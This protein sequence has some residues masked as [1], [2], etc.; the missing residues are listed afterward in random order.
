MRKENFGKRLYRVVIGNPGP[1]SA[2][3]ILGGVIVT[4]AQ[5][6]LIDRAAGA[7]NRAIDG[8]I[9]SGWLG[10]FVTGGIWAT[11]LIL[12][13]A[14]A[15]A[16]FWLG[17]RVGRYGYGRRYCIIVL[18][19]FFAEGVAHRNRLIPVIQNFD[20]RNEISIQQEWDADVLQILRHISLKARSKFRT[21]N[22]YDGKFHMAEGKDARQLHIE[23]VWNEKLDRLR[24][25]IDTAD[26]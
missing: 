19:D 17:T 26:E 21:L 5:H 4:I 22:L 3:L 11:F 14:F 20:H 9:S 23:S 8:A 13:G 25:I 2:L 6:L 15:L 10:W 18:D 16:A 24:S 1:T 12:M 7:A